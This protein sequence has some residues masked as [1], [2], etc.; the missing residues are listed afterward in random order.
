LKE[1]R[2]SKNFYLIFNPKKI[3]F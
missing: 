1:V 2:T 3:V